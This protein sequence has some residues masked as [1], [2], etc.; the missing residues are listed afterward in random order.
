MIVIRVLVVII[1]TWVLFLKVVYVNS[2]S[3][4]IENIR[5]ILRL[6]KDGVSQVTGPKTY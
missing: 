1:K 4:K 6:P 2:K 3:L 5:K